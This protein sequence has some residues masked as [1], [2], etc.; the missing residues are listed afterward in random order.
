MSGRISH[1]EACACQGQRYWHGG[2]SQGCLTLR[3]ASASSLHSPTTL[4]GMPECQHWRHTLLGSGSQLF[5]F[6]CWLHLKSRVSLIPPLSANSNM[7][8]TVMRNKVTLKNAV[9]LLKKIGNIMKTAYQKICPGLQYHE[10]LR[11]M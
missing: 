8:L 3:W 1:T 7:V 5:T 2:Q 11:K 9:A 4:K 6:S 10:I